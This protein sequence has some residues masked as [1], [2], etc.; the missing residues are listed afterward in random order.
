M[1]TNNKNRMDITS[2]IKNEILK[3]GPMP[4]NI[5][6]QKALKG[7]NGYYIN[8][9]PIGAKGDF[10]T[11]PEVSQ[12]FGEIIGI[13]LTLKLQEIIPNQQF[14]LIELGPGKGTLMADLLRAIKNLGNIY[15]LL[16]LYF[17]EINQYLKEE[18]QKAIST[19]KITWINE[20]D[21]LPSSPAIIIANEFFDALPVIQY[22]KRKKRWY[23]LM[24]NIKKDTN[25]LYIADEPIDEV[26]Q[27][28]LIKEYAH[29]PIDGIIEIQQEA[30]EFIKKICGRLTQHGG[31]CL[32][33]DYGFTENM[34][35]ENSFI[36]TLQAVKNHQYA[37]LFEC[38][39]DSDLTTQVNFSQLTKTVETHC[40]KCQ[41][42]TQREF[43]LNNGIE[44]R[45][46]I[47]LKKANK[48]QQDEII[49][50]YN[51]LININE[52]G[53]L[54]KAMIIEPV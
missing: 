15:Q 48:K 38:I 16:E 25:E 31:A 19:H 51:R 14:N 6:M 24:V 28:N 32:I 39:G 40:C 27:A 17:L 45:K 20:L 29:V 10:I 7:K 8:S 53:Q 50:G 12:L 54:F 23:E 34:R 4:I 49:S 43:L 1:L 18:Q 46:D 22:I 9:Y 21:Q 5:F 36:S 41:I 37:R 2:K 35:K 44:L 11:A 13:W 3:Y 42:M 33:V 52:M 30:Q 26:T 47:L